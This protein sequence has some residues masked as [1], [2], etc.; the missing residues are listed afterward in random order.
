MQRVAAAWGE[1]HG[2]PWLL[3]ISERQEGEGEKGTGIWL[4]AGP[5]RG[6]TTAQ[7]QLPLG[8]ACPPG[9]EVGT[10]QPS[11][12]THVPPASIYPRLGSHLSPTPLPLLRLHLTA[13]DWE[14]PL[15]PPTLHPYT[16]L[17]TKPCPLSLLNTPHICPL[18]SI[19][20]RLPCPG[21]HPLLQLSLPPSQSP[22]YSRPQL[23]HPNL[24][25]SLAYL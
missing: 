3:G 9:S 11:L 25:I 13:S 21:H 10:R 22:P 14:S 18:L 16:Q 15:P 20:L 7:I 24:S 5:A 2:A 17:S 4:A 19:P 1:A 8:K 23:S 12:V 6:G